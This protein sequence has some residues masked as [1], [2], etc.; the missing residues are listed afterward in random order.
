MDLLAEKRQ[1]R[2]EMCLIVWQQ[3]E[4][5]KGLVTDGCDSKQGLCKKVKILAS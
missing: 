5:S 1:V 2:E 3:L 4:K